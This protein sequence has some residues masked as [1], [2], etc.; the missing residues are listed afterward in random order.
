[1]KE[2]KKFSIVKNTNNEVIVSN[3]LTGTE[4]YL[5]LLYNHQDLG[6]YYIFRNVLNIPYLRKAAFDVVRGLDVLGITGDELEEKIN[7]I[8]EELEFQES[9]FA[10]RALIEV[11]FIKETLKNHW[12]HKKTLIMLLGLLIVPESQLED[13]GNYDQKVI[14][15]N[16]KIISKDHNL[17]EVF[18]YAVSSRLEILSNFAQTD[19]LDYSKMIVNLKQKEIIQQPTVKELNPLLQIKEIW[20]KLF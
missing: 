15:E 6:K 11:N 3:N 10:Q 14:E 18:F 19:T 1:M 16:I 8:Y 17:M 13:I 4:Y 5:D 2:V 20:K 12:D 9:G 7:A